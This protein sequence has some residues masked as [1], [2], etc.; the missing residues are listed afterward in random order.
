M[1]I[2]YNSR[3]DDLDALFAEGFE[4]LF[5]A[6]GAHQGSKLGL[7]GQDSPRV[8]DG[9]SFLRRVNLGEDVSVGQKVAVIGGGNAAIDAARTARRLGSQE[10]TLIY[11]RTRAEMPAFPHEVDE[12]IHE[13]ITLEFLTAPVSI[14]PGNGNLQVEFVRMELG[15]PDESG[16]RRPVPLPGSEY[17]REFDTVI[18]AIGQRPEVPDHFHLP[19][20]KGDILEVHR[21]SLVDFEDASPFLGKEEDF[22]ARLRAEMPTLAVAERLIGFPVVELGLDEKAAIAEANRCL[23]CDLRLDLASLP[24]PPA[25][26]LE[27]TTEQVAQVPEAEG[28]FE[29]LDEEKNVL[30]I[31][32]TPNLRHSLTEKLQE[33]SQARYFTFEEEPMYTQ[34]ESEL[35]QQYLQ[36]HGQMPGGGASDLDDLF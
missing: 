9:V 20:G 35:L 3:V 12:A 34:R 14:Q 30:M 23:R 8:M 28:V 32:G 1:K 2:Q 17:T 5:L 29:L 10:V 6:I 21:G 25:H 27:F 22:L 11:R 15:D 7:K 13:G 16:R 26:W 18:A 19:L 4:A 24:H 36:Q 33:N 31:C